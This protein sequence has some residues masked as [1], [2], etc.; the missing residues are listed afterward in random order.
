MMIVLIV[1]V[2]VVVSVVLWWLVSPLFIVVPGAEERPEGFT[3]LL[4]E[5]SFVD[6][7]PGHYAS[8]Q[9][10]VLADG[11][12]HVLRFENFSVTNGPNLHV[13][14]SDTPD[15]SSGYLDLGA[16]KATEGSSNYA[17]P[18]N[19]D[20]RDYRYVVIWCVPFSVQFG[21]AELVFS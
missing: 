17:F 8:G 9:A 19:A 21:Y 11:S 16:L 1:A 6:G 15:V 5:G 4:G 18:S 3:S 10:L 7:A 14:L 12:S 2:G 13:Y 20:P